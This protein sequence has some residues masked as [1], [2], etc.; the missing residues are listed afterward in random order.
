MRLFLD[1]NILLDYFMYREPFIDD[2]LKLRIMKRFGDAELW[3]SAKSFTDVFYVGRK[4]VDSQVLQKSI[5]ESVKFLNICSIDQTDIVKAA[6][7]AWPD[8][9]DC[10]IHRAAQKIKA[11]AILTRDAKGFEMSKIP[12]FRVDAFFDWLEENEGLVYDSVKLEKIL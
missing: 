3:A 6:N 12:I 2:L 7:E 4:A 1:T 8:F 10:L 9:E 11:D 5:A